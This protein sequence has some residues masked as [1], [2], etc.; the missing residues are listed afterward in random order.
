MDILSVAAIRLPCPQCG[1]TYQVPVRDIVL[2]HHVMH[3]GCCAPVETE[4]PPV[5]QARLA[6]QE[7]ANALENA[8]RELES[9]A[10]ASGGQLVITL[11]L[12][13]CLQEVSGSIS[14]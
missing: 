9:R 6:T 3:E 13:R 11:D 8:W 1:R 12:S 5:F 14:G 2:S 7:A 4:C 10:S